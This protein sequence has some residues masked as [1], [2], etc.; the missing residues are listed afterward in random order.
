MKVMPSFVVKGMLAGVA[1]DMLEWRQ[2]V[3]D[4]TAMKPL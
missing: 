3:G 2:S 4:T 1:Q